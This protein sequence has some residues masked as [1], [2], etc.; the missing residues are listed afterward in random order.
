VCSVC[1]CVCVRVVRVKSCGV[2][3]AEWKALKRSIGI[4][5]K[6]STP[7][8]AEELKA[9]LKRAMNS[10][11]ERARLERKRA[12]AFETPKDFSDAAVLQAAKWTDRLP[13]KDYEGALHLVPR[14][15]NIVTVRFFAPP[16]P[17]HQP[18]IL[19]ACVGSSPKPSPCP[20][21]VSNYHSICILSAR[22]APTPTL[23]RGDLRLC[24]LPLT[25]LAAAS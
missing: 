12:R 19:N 7:E 21:R 24:S 13:L 1:V 9:N 14:L 5:N 23:R 16:K 25:V 4:A 2:M 3:N 10:T 11:V 20:A 17:P 18:D 22:V 15:V 8:N 6:T